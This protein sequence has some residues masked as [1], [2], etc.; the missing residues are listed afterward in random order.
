MAALGAE[1]TASSEVKKG[2]NPREQG[3]ALGEV[4][5]GL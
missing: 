4:Q 3:A 1:R 5:E 2:A